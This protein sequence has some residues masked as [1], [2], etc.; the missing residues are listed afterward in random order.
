LHRC[1]VFLV[2]VE[3]ELDLVVD[4][5]MEVDLGAALNLG[6]RCAFLMLE[7]AILSLGDAP[8]WILVLAASIQALHLEP[9]AVLA[10][11]YQNSAFDSGEDCSSLC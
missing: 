11:L 3:F 10:E 7:V 8:L 6:E 4:F 1:F 9:G 5:P 2:V